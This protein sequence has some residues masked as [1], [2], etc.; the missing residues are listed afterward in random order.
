MPSHVRGRTLCV[1]RG[2][3]ASR[4]LIL[5]PHLAPMPPAEPGLCEHL[6]TEDTA[7]ERGKRREEEGEEQRRGG[8]NVGRGEGCPSSGRCSCARSER[9]CARGSCRGWSQAAWPAPGSACEPVAWDMLLKP[10]LSSVNRERHRAYLL[11]FYERESI[12]TVQNSAWHVV[13]SV[14]FLFFCYYFV[15]LPIYYVDHD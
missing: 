13:S 5:G 14:P 9:P 2:R 8:G 4:P 3:A 1:T 15:S 6:W 11:V 7:G 10:V 12:A